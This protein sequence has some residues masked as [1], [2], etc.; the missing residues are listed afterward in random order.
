MKSSASFLL[1]G[2]CTAGLFSGVAARR[3]ATGRESSAVVRNATRPASDKTAGSP[4]VPD[5]KPDASTLPL[6]RSADTL[7]TLAAADGGALYGRLAVWLLDASAADIAAF[8]ESY[9]GKP[10]DEAVAKLVFI[11]W[12]RLDPRG[13]IAGAGRYEEHYAWWAWPAHDPAAALAAPAVD[14]DCMHYTARGIG[15]FQPAWLREHFDEIK[16]V[17]SFSALSGMQEWSDGS[18]PLESLNFLKEH[19][20]EFDKETFRNLV[21]EDPW[22]ALDWMEANPGKLARRSEGDPRLDTLIATMAAERPEDLQ[23]L[24]DQSRPGEL[25]RK[26]E[27][28]LFA[29]L[30]V[31]DPEAALA[32]A[33]ASESPVI[34]AERLGKIGLECVKTDP[35]KA[36][37]MAAEILA[38][39]PGGQGFSMTLTYPNGSATWYEVG[40]SSK[41]LMTG[42]LAKDPERMME[43]AARHDANTTSVGAAFSNLAKAWSTDDA[44]GFAGWVN[45]QSD[46]IIRDSGSAWVISRLSNEG[47]YQEAVEWSASSTKLRDS[48]LSDNLANWNRVEPGAATKWLEASALP[49][50]VKSQVREGMKS[51][52]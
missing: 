43:L 17:P 11:H 42:L 4:V 6:G 32:Q 36:F 7:E 51:H 26:A 3:F 44:A 47:R 24:A 20:V 15:E 16:A 46:P 34:A 48:Y 18:H 31:S 29:N 8:W 50:D 19:G 22:A 2:C 14:L 5:T 45:R 28:A 1:L 10:R 21:R 35:E 41:E 30:L 12:T 23:R 33:K 9:R 37:G 40:D 49:A 38:V 27:A 13:A 25:K 39:N 52:K